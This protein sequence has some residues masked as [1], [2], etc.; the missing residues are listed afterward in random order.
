MEEIKEEEEVCF[1][2]LEEM[3]DCGL[4]VLR[5]TFWSMEKDFNFI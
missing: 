4:C 5:F 3:R 1:L 2:F